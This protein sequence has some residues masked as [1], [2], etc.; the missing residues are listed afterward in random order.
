MRWVTRRAVLPGWPCTKAGLDAAL[1]GPAAAKAKINWQP[2]Q[3]AGF[4][5]VYTF[6]SIVLYTPVHHC[7]VCSSAPVHHCRPCAM[8]D[9]APDPY[10][11]AA[12]ASD[13]DVGA[14]RYRPPRINTHCE[15]L[16]CCVKR[17]LM[18][19]RIISA[20]PM[21][22]H[23]IDTHFKPSFFCDKRQ[24]MTRRAIYATACGQTAA[25]YVP[26][27][28]LGQLSPSWKHHLAMLK[29]VGPP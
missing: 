29:Q 21:A 24:P 11:A 15:P 14:S 10:A 2:S 25:L 19:R 26:L 22:R 1:E 27:H 5:I 6:V 9:A 12:P 16:L 13:G 20:R 7:R 18:T 3:S 28:F 8:A 17:H 23:V 4:A